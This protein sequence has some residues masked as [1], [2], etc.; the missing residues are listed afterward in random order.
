MEGAVGKVDIGRQGENIVA[1]YL[2]E[3]GFLVTHL[4]KG[5]RG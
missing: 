5:T 3:R 1:N 2:L 4:D